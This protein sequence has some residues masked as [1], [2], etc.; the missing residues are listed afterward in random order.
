MRGPRA[1]GWLFRC[2]CSDGC[3]GVLAAGLPHL[4]RD[5]GNGVRR[6]AGVL[7]KRRPPGDPDGR[8]AVVPASTPRDWGPVR[9]DLPV[10]SPVLPVCHD[11]VGWCLASSGFERS[12]ASL[13]LT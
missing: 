2:P 6:A 7:S 5:A 4:G 3:F 13:V 1:F 8:P 11:D 9:L 12:P 10:S